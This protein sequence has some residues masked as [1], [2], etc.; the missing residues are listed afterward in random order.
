MN[1]VIQVEKK[2][3]GP[4]VV[5]ALDDGAVELCERKGIPAVSFGA[6][7][8]CDGVHICVVLMR[9]VFHTG[10]LTMNTTGAYWRQNERTFL[11]M[12]TLKTQLLKCVR[13]H[14]A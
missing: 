2:H 1:W 13:Q 10:N 4:Y 14:A 7:Y 11:F 5:G 3:L 12:A 8:A 6:H 9:C